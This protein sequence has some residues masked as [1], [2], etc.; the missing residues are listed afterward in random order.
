[1]ARTGLRVCCCAGLMLA[2]LCAGARSAPGDDLDARTRNQLAVQASLQEGLDHLQRGHFEKAVQALEKRIA[3][4]DGNPRYLSALRDAYRGYVTQLRQAGR[5]ADA[6]RY[7][8]FLDILDPAPAREQTGVAVK[9]PLMAKADPPAPPPPSA[10]EPVK[11]P[12]IVGRGKVECDDPFDPANKAE[13]RG[14][15]EDFLLRAERE[16]GARR[17]ESAGKLYESG[18][19]R[20]AGRRSGLPGPLGLLSAVSRGADARRSEGRPAASR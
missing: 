3:L 6:Q 11:T 15:K 2:I 14:L 13:D 17:Y 9:S 12:V 5:N 1:M 19:P 7:Q 20:R 4:I 8:R 16:F 10:P 18:Q